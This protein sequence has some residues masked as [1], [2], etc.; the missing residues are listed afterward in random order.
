ME[1][2][3]EV[4]LN[5]SLTD[6][7]LDRLQKLIDEQDAAGHS[8][9]VFVSSG[10]CSGMQYGMALDNQ[11]EDD[12]LRAKFKGI[13]VVVDPDSFSYLNGATIDFV[14]DLMSGGF[15]IDNPNAISRCGCGHSFRTERRQA[16]SASRDCGCH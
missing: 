2:T 8:L 3:G 1:Q 13:D 4:T 11:V 5:I 7:A 10:G 15:R 9:R 6:Q 14:E 16:S 12:D